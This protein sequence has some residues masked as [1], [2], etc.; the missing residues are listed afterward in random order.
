MPST[1]GGRTNIENMNNGA[2]ND[3]S[4]LIEDELLEGM[5]LIQSNEN[6]SEQPLLSQIEAAMENVRVASE[7]IVLGEEAIC[8]LEH[9]LNVSSENYSVLVEK[10][11]A[12]KERVGEGKA[13]V[14]SRGKYVI[15]CETGKL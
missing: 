5:K 8:F 15:F 13:S 1:F 6:S 4:S 7:G 10:L 3:S 12:E 2:N 14:T 11:K 9:N